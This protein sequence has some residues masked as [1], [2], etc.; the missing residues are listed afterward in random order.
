MRLQGRSFF[1]HMGLLFT[2]KAHQMPAAE[3]QKAA[4]EH[5]ADHDQDRI[6][7]VQRGQNRKDE[8]CEQGTIGFMGLRL[9][10]EPPYSA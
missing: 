9:P 7:V 5:H 3:S 4:K 2:E 10:E 1:A 6:G 8:R